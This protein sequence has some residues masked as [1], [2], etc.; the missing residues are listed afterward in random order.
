MLKISDIPRAALVLGVA[1]LLPALVFLGA[2]LFG[3]VV[4]RD[5]VFLLATLYAAVILSFLGGTWWALSCTKPDHPN[6]TP[7]LAFSVIPPLAAWIAAF[8]LTRASLILMAVLFVA[9]L[10][11][12]HRLLKLGLAPPWWFDLRLP[13]SAAMAIL[14]LL[15]ALAA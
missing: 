3:P 12:D 4:W 8:Y 5:Q 7:L 1:G 9:G 2:A 11:V 14:S 10:A 13:L 15:I 6:I